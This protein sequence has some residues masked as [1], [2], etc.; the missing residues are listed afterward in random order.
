MNMLEKLE[1]QMSHLGI[2][3][4]LGQKFVAESADAKRIDQQQ[5]NSVLAVVS[6]ELENSLNKAMEL[7]AQYVGKEPPKVVIDRDF[8]F[9]RLLGQD[10]SVLSELEEKGQITPR[11][12]M[13]IMR[14]GEWF[15]D[16]VNIEQGLQETERLKAE[17]RKE[18]EA[19]L[20]QRANNMMPMESG[21]EGGEEGGEEGADGS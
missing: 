1:M 13:N 7:T 17:K 3:K 15:G 12:F 6:M 11:T 10:V 2:T 18:Q 5:A 21:D 9:Y 4:L 19:L 16:S 14:S 8:D 20:T